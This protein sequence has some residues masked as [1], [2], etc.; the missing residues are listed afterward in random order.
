MREPDGAC[1]LMF[2]DRF[3]NDPPTGLRERPA[4][5]VR[6]EYDLARYG[7]QIHPEARYLAPGEWIKYDGIVIHVGG[8]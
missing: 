3:W 4:E 8:M 6:A 7:F 1:L 2:S 5:W